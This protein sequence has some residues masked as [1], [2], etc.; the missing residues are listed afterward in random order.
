[1]CHYL[2]KYNAGILIIIL[3][4]INLKNRIFTPINLLILIGIT[5]SY[6]Y[7]V[8]SLSIE[9]KTKSYYIKRIE[10]YKLDSIKLLSKAY[11]IEGPK[12]VT[13]YIFDDETFKTF[14]IAGMADIS[15]ELKEKL[16]FSETVMTIYT[17][18]EGYENYLKKDNKNEITVFEL[19]INNKKYIDAD[20]ININREKQKKISIYVYSFLYLL[21]LII[22]FYRVTKFK[23]FK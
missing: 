3:F 20:D 5:S 22:H 11:N 14:I 19:I 9:I 8:V 21:F 15:F 2:K 18:K 13:S 17:D 1:L 7:L 12:S 23:Q 10:L 4:L 16:K 6:I